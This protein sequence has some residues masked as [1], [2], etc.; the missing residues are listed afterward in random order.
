[1]LRNTIL[2]KKYFTAWDYTTQT[3]HQLEMFFSLIIINLVGTW[4]K[5][6]KINFS[7]IKVVNIELSGKI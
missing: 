1:M 5:N 7:E 2:G 3:I 4:N 6:R